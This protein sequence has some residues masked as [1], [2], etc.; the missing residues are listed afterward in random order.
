MACVCVCVFVRARIQ[1]H[2]NRL[3]Y[4]YRCSCER[5]MNCNNGSHS[6]SGSD[7]R[8]KKKE[9]FG[10]YRYAFQVNAI[11]YRH[12]YLRPNQH[13]TN[14]P[15]LVWCCRNTIQVHLNVLLC[16]FF[17]FHSLSRARSFIADFFHPS[18]LDFFFFHFSFHVC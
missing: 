13:K 9:F 4:H 11:R 1:T 18:S 3:L 2:T 17:S 12:I 16:V 5:I 10:I 14:V 6:H 8:E 15:C 7:T